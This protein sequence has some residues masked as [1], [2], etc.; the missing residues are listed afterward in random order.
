MNVKG[1]A[2]LGAGAAIAIGIIILIAGALAM[3]FDTVDA[4]HKGVKVKFGKVIGTMDAGIQ[5]TGLFVDVFQYNLR[6]RKLQIEM[7]G[8]EGAVDKDGQSVFA[9][10]EINYRLNPASVE[11]AYK[12]VGKNAELE[13]ILNVDGI[14]REG[15][16]TVTSE[17]TSLEIFQKRPEVKQAAIAKM[18]E[19]FPTEYFTIE[20]VVVSNIDFNPAFKSAI[21]AKKV[22]EETAKAE[23]EKV[24]IAEAQAQIKI[25]EAEGEKQKVQLE[26]DA[27]AYEVIELAKAE[28]ESLKLKRLQ[29]T[30]L[31]VELERIN[32]WKAGGSQVP[33]YALGDS[34]MMMMLPSED[35]TAQTSYPPQQVN[36][37]ASVAK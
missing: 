2:A 9:R 29:I 13:N 30:P 22:A 23:T 1:N 21:E 19:N 16:K 37:V 10:I 31:M 33:K 6:T 4:S 7:T 26:A 11:K 20:N 34:S 15:F 12:S 36:V 28:A 5:W 24:K 32:A 17:Y 18:K 27:Q 3:G 8:N 35:Y 25:A 14:I